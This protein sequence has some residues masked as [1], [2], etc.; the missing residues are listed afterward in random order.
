M[1][2]PPRLSLFNLYTPTLQNPTFSIQKS[3]ISS[4]KSETFNPKSKGSIKSPSAALVR[5]PHL[6]KLIILNA[7]F[8][9]SNTQ[10]YTAASSLN[11]CIKYIIFK[12]KYTIV[13]YKMHH[14]E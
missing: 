14:F 6:P 12:Y 1:H 2:M 8:I 7:N 4:T 10:L 3:N 13:K 9:F 5:Q 11:V